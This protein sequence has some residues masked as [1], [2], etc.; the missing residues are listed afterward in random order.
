MQLGWSEYDAV[1]MERELF[2]TR[3][4]GLAE[5]PAVSGIGT[6]LRTGLSS[7]LATLAAFV[8]PAPASR[9]AN[10]TPARV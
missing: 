1:H 4:T 3:L 8:A 6:W 7:A 10:V 2:N 9:T 5:R